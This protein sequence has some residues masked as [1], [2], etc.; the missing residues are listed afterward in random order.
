MTP[1]KVGLDRIDDED[2]IALVLPAGRRAF[3]VEVREV[4]GVGG[5]L[6]PGHFVDVI[7]VFADR[8][9]EAGRA[10]TMLQDVEVLAVGQEAQE[11]FPASEEGA[12]GLAGRRPDDVERQPDASS[13]TL[14]VTPQDAQMLAL[15]QE[16]GAAIW[17]S[18]RPVGDHDVVPAEDASLQPLFSEP[19]P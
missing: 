5:L 4:T 9:D 10:I 13:A 17:L 19:L 16:S 7:A 15:V 1:Q 2:D 12:T 14:A 8:F 6:L 11:P 18:L 3:A